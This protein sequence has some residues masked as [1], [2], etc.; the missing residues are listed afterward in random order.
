MIL[1]LRSRDVRGRGGGG[2]ANIDI[3]EEHKGKRSTIWKEILTHCQVW[4][5]LGVSYFT[6]WGKNKP[7]CADHC[8][9]TITSYMQWWVNMVSVPG[10]LHTTKI[11]CW[12]TVIT[13]WVYKLLIESFMGS[14]VTKHESFPYLQDATKIALILSEFWKILTIFQVN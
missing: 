1:K 14:A 3:V 6:A 13:F 9:I 11:H 12:K 4:T 5:T 7:P 8:S 2:S 10:I